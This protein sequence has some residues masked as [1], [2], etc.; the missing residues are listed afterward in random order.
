[1]VAHRDAFGLEPI[2]R[3]LSTPDR[4]IASCAVRSAIA[5]PVCARSV[6][7]REIRSL[8]VAVFN[9]NYR[10]YGRRKI[11]AALKRQHGLIIDKDRVARLM[12]ELGL[13]GVSRSRSIVTTRPNP[14]AARPPDLVKR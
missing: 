8:I 12:R 5:R 7:D 2:C 1:M 3:V 14:T 11:R 13:R 9:E 10:V 6:A 4:H